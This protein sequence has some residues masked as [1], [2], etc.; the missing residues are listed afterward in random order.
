[1]TQCEIMESLARFDA[2]PKAPEQIYLGKRQTELY[3]DEF[4]GASRKKERC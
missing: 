4:E 1:M 3:G 2:Y